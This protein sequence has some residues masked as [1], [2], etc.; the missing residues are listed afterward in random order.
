V[1]MF[2]KCGQLRMVRS[3]V[4]TMYQ[5]PL[6]PMFPVKGVVTSFREPNVQ[7]AIVKEKDSQLI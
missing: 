3:I 6:S 5:A 4:P 1:E 7:K 2:G